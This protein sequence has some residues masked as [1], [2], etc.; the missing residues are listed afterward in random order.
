MG[1]ILGPTMLQHWYE[2]W[3]VKRC[4]CYN[5]FQAVDENVKYYEGGGTH[6]FAGMMANTPFD[7]SSGYTYTTQA[8]TRLGTTQTSLFQFCKRF[9]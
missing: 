1:D 5:A 9:K 3:T 2:A 7:N 4:T 6:F 8:F